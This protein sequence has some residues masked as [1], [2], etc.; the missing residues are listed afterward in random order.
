[1]V[2]VVGMVVYDGCIGRV[3]GR[4]GGGLVRVQM[5]VDGK[6]VGAASNQVRV[7]T[8]EEK[9]GL[10]TKKKKMTPLEALVEEFGRRANW[11]SGREK[12]VWEEAKKL[13]SSLKKV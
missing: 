10:A 4:T 11:S 3:V 13:L 12:V 7:L 5:E 9:K 1:M 2:K 8:A 6:I